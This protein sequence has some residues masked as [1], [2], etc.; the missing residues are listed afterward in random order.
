MMRVKARSIFKAASKAKA[1]AARNLSRATLEI[2]QQHGYPERRVAGC[3]E[4]G[5]GCLAGPVVAAIVVL[6]AIYAGRSFESPSAIDQALSGASEDDL[7]DE[8]GGLAWLT[9]VQD[10]KTVSEKR[11]EKLAPLIQQWALGW[12]IGSASP[13]EIDQLNIAQATHLA[14]HRAFEALGLDCRPEHVLVDGNQLPKLAW[15]VPRTAVVRG[16]QRCLSIAAAS[17]LAKVFR[18]H[19][20]GELAEQFP[21]YGFAKHKGYATR[22][23]VEVLLAHGRSDLHRQSFSYPG[24]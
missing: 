9:Q 23:H 15:G 17:I 21:L 10:S 16:D 3:D 8:F 22:A 13:Q 5:R 24:E 18:D 2:E 19:W 20:M 11:R 1:M 12:G 7:T 14:M 6:P 4:V